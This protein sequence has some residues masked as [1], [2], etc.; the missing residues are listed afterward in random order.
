MKLVATEIQDLTLST[1]FLEFQAPN[2]TIC[3]GYK[4]TFN[5]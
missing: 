4:K 3:C 1:H 2:G 5:R